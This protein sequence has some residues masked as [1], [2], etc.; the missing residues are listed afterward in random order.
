[1]RPALEYRPL[2]VAEPFGISRSRS[3]ELEPIARD[4]GATLRHGALAEDALRYLV[5][6][7]GAERLVMG[8][9]LPFDM[10]PPEPVAELRAALDDEEAVA[11]I[12][13]R[14][15]AALYRW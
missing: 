7:V 6:K 13:E 9:D 5:A 3:Y 11:A 15:P 1:P 4:Q 2:A 10:A 14:N 8:T 12:A